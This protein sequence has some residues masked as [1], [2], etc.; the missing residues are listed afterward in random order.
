MLAGSPCAGWPLPLEMR[1][2][3][4][5]TGRSCRTRRLI[6]RGRAD[7]PVACDAQ[8]AICARDI[9]ADGPYARIPPP[10]IFGRDVR[11]YPPGM[12]PFDPR[13]R[14]SI[15]PVGAV[16]GR[17]TGAGRG[18]ARQAPPIAFLSSSGVTSNSDAILASSI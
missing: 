7:T 9:G 16:E 11:L 17:V 18:R 12:I 8:G 2:L 1:S 13:K 14:A 5:S 4:V 6:A 3:S 10:V 15:Q